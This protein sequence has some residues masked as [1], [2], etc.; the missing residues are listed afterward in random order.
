VELK[1]QAG[2]VDLVMVAVALLRASERPFR[3][4][5]AGRML[6]RADMLITV[7]RGR[8]KSRGGE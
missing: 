7:T 5:G 4:S 1:A 2:N 6:F 3:N 8:L